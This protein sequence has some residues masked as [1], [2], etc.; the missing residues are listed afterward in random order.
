MTASQPILVIG[1]GA[2]GLTLAC[3]LARHGAAVRIIDKLP[4]I[5][6]FARATTVHSR[7]LEVF[8]DLGIADSIIDRAAPIRGA[9]QYAGGE[10]ILHYRSEGLDSPFPFGVSVEQWKVEETLEALL[11]GFDLAV[12]RETELV[13]LE[14]SADEVRVTLRRPDG[15]TE[16]TS[17]PWLIG[18][19]GAHSTVRHLMGEHFPGETDPRRYLV[20][21]VVFN[22]GSEPDEVRIYL[23]DAGVLWRLPLPEGRSLV[24]GDACLSDDLDSTPSLDDVQAMIEHR[25]PPGTRV[26][27]AR[28][29]SWYHVNYRLTSH[30]RHGRTFLAGDAAHIHSP[31]GGQ[32][33][34]TG[35]QDAYNLGWKLALVSREIAT[36]SLLDSYEAER[37]AVA[38]DVLDFSRSMTEKAEQYVTLP[39]EDRERLYG[40][41]TMPEADRMKILRHSEELDLDYRQSPLC[42]DCIAESDEAPP[43]VSRLHA[44]A[45]A[46]DT[47]PLDV[48]GSNLQLFGLLG[49]THHTLLLVPGEQPWSEGEARELNEMVCA[50]AQDF[51]EWIRSFIVV[52]AGWDG[53]SAST[54]VTAAVLDIEGALIRRY[55]ALNARIYLIRPDGYIGFRG[56]TK[57]A[58]DLRA[59]LGRI[60]A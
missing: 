48:N 27:E 20:A 40:H 21:D 19:D 14:Q 28:W 32:G 52:P 43:A 4:G 42:A 34:N 25:A 39:Q 3:E 18:C 2:T 38:K 23:T 29:K 56:E 36:Q 50:I 11:T 45:E 47:G 44:G 22:D 49:G 10:L 46:R 54:G 12:E 16:N 31:I 60:F 26:L 57:H 58:R 51:G 17:T 41:L 24:A 55:G 7:T 1:A 33:M 15:S 59:H 9:N 30:Y 37:R 5:M 35:I 53:D 6:P 8:Q 13:A